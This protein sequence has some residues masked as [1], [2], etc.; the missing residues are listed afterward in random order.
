MREAG[1]PYD[2]YRNN[3]KLFFPPVSEA[4]WNEDASD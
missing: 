4:F 2:L 3:Y 1:A